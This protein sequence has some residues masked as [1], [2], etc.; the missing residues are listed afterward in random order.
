M[1]TAPSEQLIAAEATAA[2]SLAAV[3]EAPQS[4]APAQ[5]I[6]E[7]AA[8]IRASWQKELSAHFDRHKRYP[9]E[10]T[11]KSAEIIV[12]FVLDR[13]GHILSSGIVRGSGDAAFDNAA[14][15]MLQRSDPVPA[16][17]P[18]VADEGLSFTLPVVFRVK[19]KK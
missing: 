17:P 3:P 18:L 15:A 4:V 19:G 2:P 13:T 12:S 10:R 5:G 11:H 1:Q 7:S 8:R 16:P 6:G 9:G 14:L